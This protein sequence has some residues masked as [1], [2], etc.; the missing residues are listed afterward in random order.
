MVTCNVVDGRARMSAASTTYSTLIYVIENWQNFRT[1]FVS[2]KLCRCWKRKR[3]IYN[4]HCKLVQFDF[5]IIVSDV[6]Q[7]VVRHFQSQAMP[8]DLASAHVTFNSH[9]HHP[10]YRERFRLYLLVFVLKQ[11]RANRKERWK[12]GWQSSEPSF[13]GLNDNFMENKIKWIC[14][15]AAN[16]SK[17][18][19]YTY[20]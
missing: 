2:M 19:T 17:A 20:C 6:L 10:L 14:I 1:K 7:P 12:T 5:C 8:V 11:T 4:L 13:F 15:S 9:L 3:K 18:I 16:F